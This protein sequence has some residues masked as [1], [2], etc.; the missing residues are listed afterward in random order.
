VICKARKDAFTELVGRGRGGAIP[1]FPQSR[2][3]DR[4]GKVE[5]QNPD[6]QFPTLVS[7]VSKF[8]NG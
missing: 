5:I 8:K 3:R 6:S 2:H 4:D 7:S 1:T